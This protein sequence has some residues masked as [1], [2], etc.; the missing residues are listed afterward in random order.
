MLPCVRTNDLAYVSHTS[1]GARTV[2]DLG[3]IYSDSFATVELRP[4]SIRCRRLLISRR[5]SNAKHYIL[6][7]RIFLFHARKFQSF[8]GSRTRILSFR[9]L[10]FFHCAS[11]PLPNLDLDLIYFQNKKT[12]QFFLKIRD[13][14]AFLKQSFYVSFRPTLPSALPPPTSDHRP[15]K[16]LL[17]TL[18]L[19]PPTWGQSYTDFTL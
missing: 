1:E 18:P 4:L 7:E 6:R 12:I 16:K 2:R 3:P 17:L 14:R 9:S 19:K 10:M 8:I 11:R 13:K 5:V 15:G